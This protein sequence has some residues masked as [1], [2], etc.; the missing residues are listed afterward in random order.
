MSALKEIANS[1]IYVDPANI[2]HVEAKDEETIR[3]LRKTYPPRVLVVA[4]GLQ[5][6]ADC[7][8]YEAALA[9]A[10]EIASWTADQN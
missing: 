8:T 4:G 6:T 1:G 3:S 2:T 5:S 9:L 7:E 10:K